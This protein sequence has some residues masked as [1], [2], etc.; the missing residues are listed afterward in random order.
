MPKK[1]EHPRLCFSER[2]IPK[3]REKART[4]RWLYDPFLERCEGYVQ[5]PVPDFPGFESSRG[6]AERMVEELSLPR[7]A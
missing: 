5:I 3:L 6:R 2:E 4:C 7:I 1:V